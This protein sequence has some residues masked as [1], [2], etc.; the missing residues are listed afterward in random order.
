[1][2]GPGNSLGDEHP[3]PFFLLHYLD[4]DFVLEQFLSTMSFLTADL[5]IGTGAVLADSNQWRRVRVDGH[6]NITSL[7]PNRVNISSGARLSVA[8]LQNDRRVRIT[9]HHVPFGDCSLHDRQRDG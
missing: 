4:T 3:G 9:Q 1:M 6:R 2:A 8:F 5:P 7:V